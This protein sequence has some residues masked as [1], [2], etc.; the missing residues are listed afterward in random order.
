MCKAN[1]HAHSSTFVDF[2]VASTRQRKKPLASLG[3]PWKSVPIDRR[4]GM[5]ELIRIMSE[6]LALA[7]VCRFV[8]VQFR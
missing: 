2:A 4:H 7:W 1:N 3:T 8:M 5:S 6:F